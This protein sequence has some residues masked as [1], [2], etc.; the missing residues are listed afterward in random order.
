M[1]LSPKTAQALAGDAPERTPRTLQASPQAAAAL[2]PQQLHKTQRLVQQR[3]AI[4]GECA[5][6]SKSGLMRRASRRAPHLSSNVLLL[7]CPPARN[8]QLLLA[9]ERL[10]CERALDIAASRPPASERRDWMP[11]KQVGKIVERGPG[12]D[13]WYASE[14]EAFIEPPSLENGVPHGAGRKDRVV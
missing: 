7:V 11:P 14:L 4:A 6:R 5:K 13:D 9:K 2:M 3:V 12:L 1:S 10:V 8:L